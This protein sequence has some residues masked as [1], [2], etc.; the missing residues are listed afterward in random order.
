MQMQ[1][2]SLTRRT[3]LAGLVL[4]AATA[5]IGC[6]SDEFDPNATQ[7]VTRIAVI[8]DES[9]SFKAHLP[10]AA[11]IIQRFIRENAISGSAE[12]YLVTADRAPQSYYF[13]AEQLLNKKSAGVLEKITITNP[14][15][16]TDIVGALRLAHDKLTKNNGSKPGK[17]YLLCFSDM[18]ADRRPILRSSFNRWRRSIGSHFR[19]CSPSSISSTG[20]TRG[21]STASSRRPGWAVL[22]WTPPKVSRRNCLSRATARTSSLADPPVG[23]PA[24]GRRLPVVCPAA[25]YAWD[26]ARSAKPRCSLAGM[27][28]TG[29]FTRVVLDRIAIQKKEEKE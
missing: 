17:Q 15:D 13:P 20:R 26:I 9:A 11:A 24:P 27:T 18:Y 1:I 2:S 8:V 22:F 6:D 25:N 7:S 3:F 21:L 28:L 29:E 10:A 5:L 23:A 12:I 16:G 4:V 19:G 14:L